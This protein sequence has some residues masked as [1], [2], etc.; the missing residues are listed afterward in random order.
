M[1]L[2][3][4]LTGGIRLTQSAAPMLASPYSGDHLTQAIVSDY[5]GQLPGE[6]VDRNIARRV[7]EVKRALAAH[8]ALVTRLRFE[9]YA[10]GTPTARVET[11][12]YWVST[13]AY[14]GMSRWL[15]YKQLVEEL[16]FEGFAVI[17]CWLD[18]EGLV[19]DWITVPRNLWTID[20]QTQSVVIDESVPAQYR[21]RAV[22]VP[23]GSAGLMVDGIDSIRQARKIEIARQA[24]LDSPPAATELHVTDTAYDSMERDEQQTLIANYKEGRSKSSISVTPSYIEVKERGTSGSLDLFEEA[25]N[26]VRIDLA[27][28]TGVTLNFVG[29]S[30]EGGGSGGSVQY[31]NV[32]GENSELWTFGASEYAIAIAAALSAD[33]VVG[34]GSEVRADASAF[35]VPAP[36]SIDPEA[37]DSAASTIKEN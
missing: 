25:K 16:F 32:N 15:A 14:S 27:M 4:F 18:T 3:N 17:G 5:F 28:H 30:K 9:V 31:Q 11:Q 1:G 35:A 21:M 33:V 8:Q 34:E 22:V 23:L 7:P 13:C 24:R 19:Y 37:G 36:L 12:P 29:A 26:S 20:Q 6:L 2:F 10:A